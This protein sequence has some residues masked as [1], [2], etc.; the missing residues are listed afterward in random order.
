ML[1][2]MILQRLAGH[3]GLERIMGIR[4]IGKVNDMVAL[5]VNDKR[6]LSARQGTETGK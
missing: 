6:A 1:V 4:Q 5:L 3:V 2:V